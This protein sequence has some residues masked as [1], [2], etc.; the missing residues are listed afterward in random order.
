MSDGSAE[1][2]YVFIRGSYKAPGPTVPRRFLEALAGPNARSVA[3]RQR[4]AG[5]G[6]ANDRSRRRSVRCRA[7]MVNRV[8][9]HLFGRG[10]VASTDNFGVLGE[11]P[12]HPELLDYLADRFVKDGWSIKKLIRALVLS[13]HL[14]HVER[15][16]TTAADRADPG[17]ICCCTGC[18]VR[19]LEGEAIRDAML[20]VS[21]RLDERMHGPSVPVH[22]TPF[23]EGRGRPGQRSARRRRPPQS[24]SRRAPQFPVAD[25]ARLRYAQSVF[26]GRPPHRL[27]RAGAVADSDER[28]VRSSAGAAVGQARAGSTRI[29]AA[30]ASFACMK[31]R[32]LVRPRKR[33]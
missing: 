19:R 27:Q 20:T 11:R 30:S 16:R 4:P 6:A 32:S 8:W 28:S 13:Q 18:G 29:D 17:K 3:A 25:S 2:E 9:H 7:C 1:N 15:S 31:A 23:Q 26:H 21:G 5:T 33:N 24:V 10:I 12:T 22:L 14:P